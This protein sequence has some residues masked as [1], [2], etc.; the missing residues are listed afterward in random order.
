MQPLLQLENISLR[1][2]S[3]A[4]LSDI[5]LCLLPEQILT[6]I[7]PNGAGKT[8]LL[9][10]V[11]GIER[12][13]TGQ[14]RKQKH[15]RL[16]YMPQRLTLDQSLPISVLRLLRLNKGQVSAQECLNALARTEGAH[17]ANNQVHQLSGGELQRVLL[18]RSLLNQPQLLVLDEPVQGVDFLGEA[19]MYQLIQQVKQELRAAVLMVSHDLHVVMAQSDEVLCI[20]THICCQ[21]HPQSISSNPAY[22]QLFGKDAAPNLGLYVHE[23]D[24][25]HDLH[26]Q[27]CRHD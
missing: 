19:Q 20:N 3:Q 24:H 8:S 25:Q 7:G 1:K 5:S 14:I 4:I 27:G 23:H 21:G 10:V 11:L 12:P 13:S 2:G 22:L 17:L 9:K 15:L 26:Q 18:A 6:I 16:G